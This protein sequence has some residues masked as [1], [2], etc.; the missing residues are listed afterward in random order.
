MRRLVVVD[1]GLGRW[2]RIARQ[3]LEG[4]DRETDDRCNFQE[5]LS[6]KISA[7]VVCTYCAIRR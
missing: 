6:L 4:N 3:V 5:S 2:N 7:G 1:C